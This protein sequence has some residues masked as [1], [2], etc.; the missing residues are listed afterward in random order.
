MTLHKLQDPGTAIKGG[1]EPGRILEGTPVWTTAKLYESA[2][3]AMAAGV[4]TSTVGKWRVD[5]ARWEYMILTEGRCVLTPDG[6]EP[7]SLGVGDS[8]VIEPGFVGT[9]EVTE[10][11][12]K[13][14]FAR[15]R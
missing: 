12:S 14:Y 1:P 6:G 9:W 7:I 3:G 11:M 15:Y 10:P 13:R 8:M 4:W 5:I 2:E